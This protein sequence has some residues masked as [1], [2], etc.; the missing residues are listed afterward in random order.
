MSRF[1][2]MQCLS[3]DIVYPSWAKKWVNIRKVFCNAY[4][5]R[6]G[7]STMLDVLGLAF[8]G[9][10]HSGIDDARNIARIL[11]QLISDGCNVYENE[12][13]VV[14]SPTSSSGDTPTAE[15]SVLQQEDAA[16]ADD[17]DNVDAKHT[18]RNADAVA[19]SISEEK[20]ECANSSDECQ[21]LLT[22]EISSGTV[23]CAALLEQLSV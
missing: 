19:S 15:V 12:V 21:T 11:A 5:V 2:Y 8:E 7:V 18:S 10:P 23:N 16:S 17:D 9:H 1:L 14:S 6:G 4:G 3:S 22:E 13:L 20:T